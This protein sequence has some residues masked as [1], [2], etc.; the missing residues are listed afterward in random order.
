[1]LSTSEIL[2]QVLEA[3]A[4]RSMLSCERTFEELGFES[5]KLLQ[6]AMEMEDRLAIFLS[7]ADFEKNF[8][9]PDAG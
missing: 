2:Y 9:V 5:L 3:H 8:F 7:D 6:I 1:M 4:P